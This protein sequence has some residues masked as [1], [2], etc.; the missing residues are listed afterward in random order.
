MNTEP[1]REFQYK[2][3]VITAIPDQLAESGR[4]T[5]KV[6]IEKHSP[7]GVMQRPY[8]AANT[9]PTEE[10]AIKHSLNLGKQ[11]IDGEAEVSLDL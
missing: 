8:S 4:W 6:S 7:S 2:G 10:E 9:F 5:V 1:K 3:Y 11:I